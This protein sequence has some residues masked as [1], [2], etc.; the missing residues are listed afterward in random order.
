LYPAIRVECDSQHEVLQITN[1]TAY[2]DDGVKNADESNGVYV[3]NDALPSRENRDAPAKEH[4]CRTK[5]AEFRVQLRPLFGQLS[6]SDTFAV[7]V[8]RNGATILPWLN[9]DADERGTQSNTYVTSIVARTTGK[10]VVTA[11]C[12]EKVLLNSNCVPSFDCAK[13]VSR[14]EHLICEDEYLSFVD[15]Q[16]AEAYAARLRKASDANRLRDEQRQWLKARNA[17]TDTACLRS[18][19]EL[20]RSQLAQSYPKQ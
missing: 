20:R 14:V 4:I 15:Y 18:A 5:S 7:L 3:P 8:K 1:I 9:L 13:A 2:N 10:P 17:C 12:R 19:Y 16:L 6:T 11:S